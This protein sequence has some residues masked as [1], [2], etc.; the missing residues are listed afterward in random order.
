MFSHSGGD[1]KLLFELS[2]CKL[3]KMVD[4]KKNIK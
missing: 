4:L 2:L 1:I 3:I